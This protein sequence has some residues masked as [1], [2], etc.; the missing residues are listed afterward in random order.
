MNK[1]HILIV[2]NLF[3]SRKTS[4]QKLLQKSDCDYQFSI[5]AD[6]SSGLIQYDCE[7]IDSI[8]LDFHLPDFNGLEF[9]KKLKTK[10]RNL[11]PIILLYEPEQDSCLTATVKEQFYQCLSKD[12]L[13]S[14]LLRQSL[15]ELLNAKYLRSTLVR[16]KQ[17]QKLITDTALNIRKS[18]SLKFILE[19]ASQ[20]L[21]SFLTCD[22]ISTVRLAQHDIWIESQVGTDD[23]AKGRLP[24]LTAKS[25]HP[26]TTEGMM[27]NIQNNE[28]Q[29]LV[30]ILL[31]QAIKPSQY[32]PL[33][34]WLIAETVE[35]REWLEQERVF[36]QQFA[37][38]LSIAFSQKLLYQQLQQSDRQLKVSVMS[39]QH[40]K[41]L[42]LKDSLTQV[43]N[44]RYFKQQL[45]KEW[46]RLRRINAS[47][48]VVLCDVDCFKLYNDTYGHQL[49]DQCLQKIAEA[50][51]SA[52][53]RSADILSRYGGEEFIAILPDT[54]LDGAV[55]VAEKIRN[56]VKE[57]QIPHRN[58]LVDSVVTIS[59]GAATTVPHSRDNPKM[60]VQAADNAL[61]LAKNRGRD[62]I[63]VHRNPIALSNQEQKSDLEWAKRIRYALKQD[64][65]HLYVQPITSLKVDPIKHFEILL[66]LEDRG[67]EVFSPG[68]FFDAAERNCLMPSIDTWVVNQLLKQIAIKKDSCDWDSYQFSINLSGASLNDPDFLTFL[69]RRLTECDFAPQIFCFEITE[70][71]A[72]DNIEDVCDFIAT[73]K[74]LGCKFSLDDFGKGMSSLSYL[75][76]LPIDYLKIDGSFITELN[77]DKVSMVMVEAIDH[78]A[79]GM[80]L[81]TIAEYVE[82]QQILN[83]LRSL[84]IDYVQ[85]YHLGKPKRFTDIFV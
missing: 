30:P 75:K 11:P 73:L 58:S 61:Y 2:E 56:A 41:T 25:L 82:N 64:L 68:F 55:K 22:R 42:T 10:T 8:I 24:K 52:L 27:G 36:L 19:T 40:L 46:F 33:W 39:N 69:S 77:K 47:L 65:F 71:I 49:G 51:S 54:D 7:Q 57:L 3:S 62:C 80:G 20:E 32:Y 74:K 35:P 43:Y 26:F 70:D 9:V 21:S 66:R 14:Q 44:R 81:K 67:E 78:L 12:R 6:G 5:A 72:I 79:T 53:K 31:E 63:A 23:L 18:L 48:S 59:A 16:N 84:N 29:L 50:M 1:L 76:N 60:L 15:D 83:T 17:Q 34:G 28:Q 85:G 13:T 38:Q 37:I 45:N 4:S